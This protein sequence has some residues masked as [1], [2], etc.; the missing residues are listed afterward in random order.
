MAKEISAP[1]RAPKRS[2][3]SYCRLKSGDHKRSFFSLAVGR[4]FPIR[5]D[6][7]QLRL[8]AVEH[9]LP[10]SA[11]GRG[12]G[13]RFFVKFR[14]EIACLDPVTLIIPESSLLVLVDLW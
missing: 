4:L 12:C 10:I 6:V 9:V 13:A 5:V 3:K 2:R 1:N 8:R 11:I 7:L 14:A